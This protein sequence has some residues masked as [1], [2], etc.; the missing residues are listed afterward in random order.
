MCTAYPQ[1]LPGVC[2]GVPTNAF[3]PALKGQVSRANRMNPPGWYPSPER[4]GHMQYWDGIEWKSRMKS[5]EELPP[6]HN[7]PA[8]PY[9]PAAHSTMETGP[10]FRSATTVRRVSLGGLQASVFL[11]LFGL[12]FIG[13][14]SFT[15]SQSIRDT[16]ASG[17]A[18]EGTVVDV[19]WS[20]SRSSRSRSTST[21]CSP[22][23]SFTLDGREYTVSSNVFT[24]PCKWDLGQP[25]ELVY[26]PANPQSARP[27]SALNLAAGIFPVIGALIA[28]LGV[29]NG[30]R[31]IKARREAQEQ[32]GS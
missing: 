16:F 6:V 21:N 20:D 15:L 31:E 10:G 25:I 17:P 19:R 23:S 18:V 8:A 32:P 5:P 1:P 2:N 4:A 13:I 24:G 27:K 9:G 11:V 7:P 12:V 30:I 3:L 29:R 28:G 22:V 26:D 14:G